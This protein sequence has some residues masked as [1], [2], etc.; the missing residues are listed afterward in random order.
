MESLFG[1]ILLVLTSNSHVRELLDIGDH[2]KFHNMSIVLSLYLFLRNNN[3]NSHPTFVKLQGICVV[4]LFDCKQSHREVWGGGSE[5]CAER[6]WF[7]IGGFDDQIGSF[8]KGE[9]LKRPTTNWK[10]VM[11][12]EC[13]HQVNTNFTTF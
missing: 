6:W 5:V 2:P 12:I 3:C 9:G 7:G 10:V 13:S 11:R 8:E 1:N 4:R